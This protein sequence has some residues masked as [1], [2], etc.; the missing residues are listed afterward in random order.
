EIDPATAE[1]RIVV[2]G[3]IS[4]EAEVTLNG[5]PVKLSDRKFHETILLKE[6]NNELRLDAQD[7]AGNR[8]S[9][10]KTVLHDSRP[11]EIGRHEVSP[12]QTKGGEVAQ[13]SVQVGDEGA[14]AARS[15]SFTLEV[16]GTPFKGILNR[17]SEDDTMYSGT[18]FVLPG[19]AGTVLVREIR[20]QDLLG[21]LAEYRHDE[22]EK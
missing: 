21:N 18:V 22:K 10:K 2:S 13:F 8:S 19:V 6:G 20:V 4:E 5:A 1:G 14:G 17:G 7:A 12:S 11:P 9:W 3:I 16:N 15:G